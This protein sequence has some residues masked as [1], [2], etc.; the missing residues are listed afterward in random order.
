MAAPKEQPE[1]KV[2]LDL[3]VIAPPPKTL[4]LKGVVYEIPSDIPVVTLVQI[5][6]MREKIEA[7][8][9]GSVDEQVEAVQGLFD[10]VMNLLRA[11]RPDM[12]EL[13]VSVEQL[14]YIVGMILSGIEGVTMDEALAHALSG[15]E[16][17]SKQADDDVPPTKSKPRKKAA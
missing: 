14:M 2:D 3:D 4:R 8:E 5:V 1:Q 16:A 11:E 17:T 10:V 13:T 6:Q 12:P 9:N 7:A 15:G